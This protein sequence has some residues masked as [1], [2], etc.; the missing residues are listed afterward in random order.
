MWKRETFMDNLML[1][2]ILY[3]LIAQ[4]GRHETLF[5][6][7]GLLAEEAFVRS[8]AG[9]AFPLLWF[10]LPL[11]GT[12]WLDLHVNHDWR[13]VHGTDATLAGLTGVY[14]DAFE[15]FKRQEPDMVK[16]FAL[17]WDVSSGNVDA[18]AVQMLRGGRKLDDPSD[19]LKV[20][21]RKD[22]VEGYRTF[23]GKTPSGW[24]NCYTGV[25][26]GR[27]DSADVP[28]S[29]AEC[30]VSDKLQADYI[31]D[32]DVLRSDL[33]GVGIDFLDDGA[34]GDIQA[35]AGFGF[36]TEFQFNVGAGGSA[37]PVLA[38]SVRFEVDDWLDEE[39]R[40]GV[41][42][43]AAWFMRKGYADERILE[44]P[45]M[46]IATKVRRGD[47]ARSVRSYPAFLKLRWREGMVPDGKAYLFGWVE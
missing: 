34:T 31:R 46:L 38:A 2:R 8:M 32:A 27:S 43:L 15:W 24:Y 41:Y 12:P 42:G 6:G 26:P 47:E 45:K 14:A 23:I 18:P 22:L 36:R 9:D 40:K 19:F 44:F 17:S 7:Y 33:E 25:F 10:E 5:G 37:L 35:I 20:V 16:E 4:D 11:A 3:S 21:G 39:K 29:R 1:Y 13:K 28:W 30:I